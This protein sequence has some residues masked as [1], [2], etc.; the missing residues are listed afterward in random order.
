MPICAEWFAQSQDRCKQSKRRECVK[1]VQ[2][3]LS[4]EI[5]SRTNECIHQFDAQSCFFLQSIQTHMHTH[6]AQQTPRYTC[7]HALNKA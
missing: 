5:K 2:R 6:H 4:S 7:M 1:K 3:S